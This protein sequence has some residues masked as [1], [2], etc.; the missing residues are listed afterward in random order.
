[1]TPPNSYY[2]PGLSTAVGACSS[3]VAVPI[4]SRRRLS[5]LR[6]L[7]TTIRA[8]ILL[9]LLSSVLT[10]RVR[11]DSIGYGRKSTVSITNDL[12]VV[13]HTHDWSS[14][15]IKKLYFEFARHEKFFTSANNFSKITVTDQV[16]RRKA[17]GSSCP[18]LTYLWLSPDSRYLIGLSYV[19]LDNPYQLVIWDL[20][21]K[22]VLWKEHISD[23]VAILTKDEFANFDSRFPKVKKHFPNWIHFQAD[24]VIVDGQVPSNP[25]LVGEGAWDYLYKHWKPHPYSANFGETSSNFVFWY[26]KTPELQLEEKDN[27]LVVS[28]L[29]PKQERIFIH[30]PRTKS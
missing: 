22:S 23:H 17:F 7:L 2:K 3:A 29:D 28:L 24:S 1:M 18:A 20:Q 13:T 4:T 19:M 15:K 11:A 27:E 5:F 9:A 25:E 21:Q 6:K 14:R 30:V 16:S 26:Y 8:G 12:Y 10:T